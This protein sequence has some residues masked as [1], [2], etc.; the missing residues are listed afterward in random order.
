MRNERADERWANDH[1]AWCADEKNWLLPHVLM[2][3]VWI[4]KAQWKANKTKPREFA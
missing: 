2:E 3:W 4:I 1:Q